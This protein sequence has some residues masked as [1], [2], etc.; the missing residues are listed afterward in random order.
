M[1]PRVCEAV[2]VCE[3]VCPCVCEAV[4]VCVCLR[5]C[6]SVH[7]SVC[8]CPRVCVCVR[9][10][11]LLGA[12]VGLAVFAARARVTQGHVHSL[13][14]ARTSAFLPGAQGTAGAC[15]SCRD[16]TSG[17]TCAWQ[18]VTTESLTS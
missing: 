14:R 11:M 15:L 4:R 5:V 1:C 18:F 16:T 17:A 2:H 12:W 13:P 7:V 10:R 6:E 3:C 9:V 8:V